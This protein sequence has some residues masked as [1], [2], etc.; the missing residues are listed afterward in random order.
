[1][2]QTPEKKEA[3]PITPEEAATLAPIVLARIRLRAKDSRRARVNE[4]RR[5]AFS[6]NLFPR[7]MKRNYKRE[8]ENMWAMSWEDAG[9]HLRLAM[10]DYAAGKR[11]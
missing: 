9:D 2:E 10:F 4:L 11:K 5:S 3:P 7:M 1:M 8:A 6:F